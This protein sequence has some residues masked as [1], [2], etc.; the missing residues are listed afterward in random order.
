MNNKEI[1]DLIN[2]ADLL[3]SEGE[4]PVVWQN[5]ELIIKRFRHK[6]WF[7]SNLLRPYAKRFAANAAELLQR[8]VNAP[9]VVAEARLEDGDDY[10]VYRCVPGKPASSLVQEPD[11][12]SPQRIAAVYADLHR[13]GV[14][15]RS[16]HLSNVLLQ[17]ADGYGLIDIT[18]VVFVKPPASIRK[19][20]RNLGYAWAHPRDEHYFTAK[21]RAAVCQAYIEASGLDVAAAQSF[22]CLLDREYQRGRDRRLAR[23]ARKAGKRGG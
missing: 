1:N 11:G 21:N 5:D 20:A 7:T 13:R 16:V 12:L 2:G 22:R 8:G 17:S 4:V 9:S 23:R 15:F 18:D 3:E 19:R 14:L 6:G 10:L